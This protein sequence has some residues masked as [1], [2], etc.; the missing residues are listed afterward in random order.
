M[1]NAWND[2]QDALSA[3][4]DH[5]GSPLERTM[6]KENTKLS[7]KLSDCEYALRVT[8]DEVARLQDKLA[9]AHQLPWNRDTIQVDR[10]QWER[11]KRY[12]K[13]L[14]WFTSASLVA[15]VLVAAAW[16]VYHVADCTSKAIFQH[17]FDVYP[18]WHSA[19]DFT[20]SPTSNDL[21]WLQNKGYILS[22]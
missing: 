18:I 15:W 2:Y 13:Q 16:I 20:I 19:P 4:A 8:E 3:F 1:T 5:C 11:Q 14:T 21:N 17:T 22:P 10:E 6:L 12:H 7:Q 9:E